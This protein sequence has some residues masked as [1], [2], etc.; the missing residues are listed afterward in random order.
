MWYPRYLSFPGV[1]KSLDGFFMAVGA[2]PKLRRLKREDQLD[3]IDAHFGYPDG[4]AAVLV[5]RWLKV[6]VTI[7]SLGAR[8]D[9]MGGL[10]LFVGRLIA[11][12][13]V[14]A[15]SMASIANDRIALRRWHQAI[16]YQFP[17]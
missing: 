4:Y 8:E 2:Y 5:G 14:V 11:F 7:T 17:R 15:D 12:A 1:L 6:P 13:V 3:V 10:E 9:V 16:K